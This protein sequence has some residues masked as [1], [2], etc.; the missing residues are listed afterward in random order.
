MFV[1]KNEDFWLFDSH[2]RGKYGLSSSDGNAVLMSF[3]TLED[4]VAFMYATYESANIDVA[5]QY[6][7]LPL[8][9]NVV[10]CTISSHVLNMHVEDEQ[11]K[12][13]N[14]SSADVWETVSFKKETKSSNI[15]VS[16]KKKKIKQLK[17]QVKAMSKNKE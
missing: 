13:D 16:E 8:S 11:K 2:S 4:L 5:S 7:I 14:S 10:E 12:T 3:S 9:C 1:C 17:M 15:P 6:E